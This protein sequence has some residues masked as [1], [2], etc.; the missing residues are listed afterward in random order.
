MLL[1]LFKFHTYIGTYT[2]TR[3]SAIT[4]TIAT[5]LD[6]FV[7]DSRHRMCV[8]F[9]TVCMWRY[10]TK[11][12]Y[13]RVASKS[14]TKS[15]EWVYF[16]MLNSQQVHR[17]DSFVYRAFGNSMKKLSLKKR[18]KGELN[19]CK[20]LLRRVKTSSVCLCKSV[21]DRTTIVNR[22]GGNKTR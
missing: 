21:H 17:F 5:V 14:C 15:T 20:R 10:F 18:E 3:T 8:S 19:N 11:R 12:L 9:F 16:C 2:L 6:I 22:C 4:A 1:L 7:V 13:F